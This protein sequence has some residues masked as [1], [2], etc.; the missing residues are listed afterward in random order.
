MTAGK[1]NNS[2]RELRAEEGRSAGYATG[3][4][5]AQ[6][7]SPLVIVRPAFSRLSAQNT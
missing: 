7:L 1:K 6:A 2:I 4:K 5:G 3:L